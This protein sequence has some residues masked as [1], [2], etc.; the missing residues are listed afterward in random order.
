MPTPIRGRDEPE[1]ARLKGEARMARVL[2]Q[3]VGDRERGLPSAVAL[4]WKGQRV[5]LSVRDSRR[6]VDQVKRRRGTHNE[7]RAQV[8]RLV[9][10]HLLGQLDLEE[11]DAREG[12]A[13]ESP[14]REAVSAT[15][16]ADRAVVTALE[17]M[18]PALTPE[19]LLHDLFGWA[20]LVRLAGRGVL[21]E[22]EVAALH[23]PRSEALGDVPWTDADLPLLDEALVY[24][25]P[26]ARRR[27]RTGT[28]NGDGAARWEREKV[29]SDLGE[30]DSLMRRDLLA[31]LEEVD[32]RARNADV[33]SLE[34]WDRTFGHVVIDEAQ[35]LSP[36]QL[37][38]IGRRVPSGSMT[39]VG[40]LG[41]ASGSWA[42]R[43]WDEVV[44]HLPS[45]ARRPPRRAELTV[46]YRTPSEVMDVAARVLA[47]AAPDLTPSQSVRQ[48]GTDPVFVAVGSAELDGAVREAARA[49]TTAVADGKVAVLTAPSM[50]EHVRTL[51][52]SA[53]TGPDL[54][55]APL[56]VLAVQQAK[57]LEFDSVVVVEPAAIVAEH[58][59]GGR[60][61][62]LALT[63]TTRRLR[64]VSSQPLPAGLEAPPRGEGTAA[65]P[66]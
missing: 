56:A 11:E 13:Q 3:A 59:H 62:Y 1:A 39:I 65:V 10:R 60:A 31:H 14:A 4:L 50:V 42:P 46:N 23:R 21:D 45:P 53:G 12:P 25:G 35:D 19:E 63:R 58:P 32:P 48:S 15:L 49:E 33:E 17:R 26:V 55:D 6:I 51:L 5:R 52:T 8:E 40:D 30:M 22:D 2:A 24:L 36:M 20:A 9:V 34:L 27:G 38:M 28:R 18:W 37:R 43:T 47:V 44:A 29:V 64:V 16:R 54:L 61:L 41:Q 7:R 57:G 66:Q